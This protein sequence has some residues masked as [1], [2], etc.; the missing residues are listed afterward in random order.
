MKKNKIIGLVN[1]SPD[2]AVNQTIARLE[3]EAK[4]LGYQTEIFNHYDFCITFEKEKL[5]IFHNE[6]KLN[7]DNYLCL[8]PTVSIFENLPDFMY[9]L[10]CAQML[11][12]PVINSPESI[13]LAKN[14]THSMITLAQAGFPVIPSAVNYSSFK[15]KPVFDFIEGEEFVCKTNKSSLGRGVSIMHSK[16]SLISAFELMAS[17]GVTPS[18]IIF[19]K[20]VKEAKGKDTRIIVIGDEV[21]ASMQRVSGGIDFRSNL[22]GTGTGSKVDCLTDEVKDMAVKAMKELGLDYGGIDILEADNGPMII[23]ANANPGIQ[24]EKI[25]GINVTQKILEYT[26]EKCNN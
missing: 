7:L 19:Q 25:T 12:L 2:V 21:I 6:E 22:C 16:I 15:L 8:I 17:K 23:E 18:T 11:G 14:K 10:N 4:K 1:F 5:T 26:I 24:I 13:C 20:Y 3:E 9:F